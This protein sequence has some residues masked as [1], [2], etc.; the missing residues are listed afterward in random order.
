MIATKNYQVKYFK[1]RATCI[2][3]IFTEKLLLVNLKIK[4]QEMRLKYC[5][6]LLARM[7]S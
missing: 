3:Y 7:H 2:N 4:T 1:K 6:F 5:S